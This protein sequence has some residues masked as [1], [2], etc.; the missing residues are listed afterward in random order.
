MAVGRSFNIFNHLGFEGDGDGGIWT[1]MEEKWRRERDSTSPYPF[2]FAKSSQFGIEPNAESS[3]LN[4]D[5]VLVPS[6]N[7]VSHHAA[8]FAQISP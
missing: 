7:G 5:F 8:N 4:V 1:A 6:K 2:S 3:L